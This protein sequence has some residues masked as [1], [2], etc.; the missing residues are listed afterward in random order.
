[1]KSYSVLTIYFLRLC[2][3]YETAIQTDRRTVQTDGRTAY[4]GN[5][6]LVQWL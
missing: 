1:M 3:S 2:A 5:T 6:T 4:G